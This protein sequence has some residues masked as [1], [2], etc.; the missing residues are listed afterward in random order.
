MIRKYTL[1]PPL[2][3]AMPGDT[4]AVVAGVLEMRRGGALFAFRDLRHQHSEPLTSPF[5]GGS[6]PITTFLQEQSMAVTVTCDN[7]TIAQNGT[8]RLNTTPGSQQEYPD[9]G[10][11]SD[12]VNGFLTNETV[13]LMILTY[14]KARNPALDDPSVVAGKTFQFDLSLELNQLSIG[15]V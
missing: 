12:A 15:V 2:P 1:S 4:F 10:A 9:A 13:Q 11:V 5:P 14:W 3:A 6:G 8:I 7:I